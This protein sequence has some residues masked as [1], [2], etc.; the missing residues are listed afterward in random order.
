VSLV[1]LKYFKDKNTD[2]LSICQ[3]LGTFM[4]E[5]TENEYKQLIE[6]SWYWSTIDDII[7]M[8]DLYGKDKVL[9]DVANY[10]ISQLTDYDKDVE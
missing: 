1:T 5:E 6:E 9:D 8:F 3:P 2:I 10:K 4:N 7:K